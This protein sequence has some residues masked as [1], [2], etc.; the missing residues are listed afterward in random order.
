MALAAL[1]TVGPLLPNSSMLR[2]KE[3]TKSGASPG[4]TNSKGMETPD[5]ADSGTSTIE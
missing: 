3:V 4:S 1:L 5:R 2:K